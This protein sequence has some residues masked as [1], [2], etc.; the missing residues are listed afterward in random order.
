[1]AGAFF[2]LSGAGYFAFNLNQ[3]VE[4]RNKELRRLYSILLQLKSEIQYMYNTLPESFEKIA[5]NEKEPFQEWLQIL[6]KKLQGKESATFLEIWK[7]ELDY[8]YKKSCLEKEDIVLLFELSD[9]LG[10]ADI[11]AQ[12]KAIDYV[13]ISL[14]KKRTILENEMVQKKKVIITLSLFLG[15]VMLILLI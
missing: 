13:L 11:A 15:F 4:N 9:K 12:M 14:E 5:T 6:A 8:L 10:S 1:M 2:L 3:I 7:Q